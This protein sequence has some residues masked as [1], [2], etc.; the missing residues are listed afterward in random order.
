MSQ[1]A[2][3]SVNKEVTDLGDEA[4]LDKDIQ[5]KLIEFLKKQNNF[6]DLMSMEKG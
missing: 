5:K 4:K 6:T 2:Y 1:L 3:G